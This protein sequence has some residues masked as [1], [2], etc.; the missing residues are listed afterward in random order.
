MSEHDAAPRN[1]RF[2]TPALALVSAMAVAA[3]LAALAAL[4]LILA[5]TA[6]AERE[7]EGGVTVHQGLLAPR[8]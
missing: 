1:P 8:S 6:G 2:R 3:T 7:A 5:E 4:L